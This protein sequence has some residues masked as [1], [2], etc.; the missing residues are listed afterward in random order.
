MTTRMTQND[1]EAL[2]VSDEEAEERSPQLLDAA[3]VEQGSQDNSSTTTTTPPNEEGGLGK[4]WFILEPAV[5][6]IFLGRYL[7]GAVYQNQIL[8]QTC[9]SLKYNETQCKPL[10]GLNKETPEAQIIEEIVQPYVSQILM[11]TSI[12]E[13]IIPA[14]VSL[15]IGPW[16]DKFGRR[17]ILLTTFTGYLISAII[18]TIITLIST[19]RHIN[20]WWFVLSSVPSAFSG[21]TCA[22]I[23]GIYCY[24]SD[25][26]KERK[27]AVRMVL[28]EAWLCTGM[29]LG[30]VGSGYIYSVTNALTLF[31]IATGLMLLALI[32]VYVFVTES[33]Q[34]INIP[35]TSRIREFFRF[36]LAKDLVRTCFQSRPNFDR[37]IIWLTIIALTLSIFVMEG[38]STVNYLFL[39]KKFLW[40]IEDF[41]SFSAARIVIQIVGSIFGMIVLRRVLK[42]SIVS[43]A[44]LAMACCVLESTVRATAAY[45]WELYVGMTLGMMRGVLGPMCRAI[46]SHVTPGS[47]VGKVFALT[48]SL[49]SISPLIAAPLYTYVYNATLLQYPG[50]FNFIS[51]GLYFLCYVLITAIFGIQKSMGDSVVYQAIGS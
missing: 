34:V 36:G 8:Y 48:T 29:M 31:C 4:R 45:S 43:M 9:I 50:T 30:S 2:L 51:A 39:R 16:S 46:L 6:L 38:E 28:N 35:G 40:T 23:T 24:I 5:F 12:F 41:S 7:I 32:Y 1:D 3:S 49:E 15:F 11:A 26:A 18:L 20:P 14:F 27:R 17:P 47:E 21:G 42:F 13:S 44:M 33:V 10:L 37:S 22:L 19:G 25:V